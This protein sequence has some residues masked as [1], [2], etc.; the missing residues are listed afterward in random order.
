MSVSHPK[1]TPLQ[2][3]FLSVMA[4][5]D[6]PVSLDVLAQLVP[7]PPSQFFELM[8]KCE[9]LNWICQDESGSFGLSDALPADVR[10]RIEKI[11]SF[12]RLVT[13]VDQMKSNNL[14]DKISFQA[15][16]N[17]L[18]KSEGQ[19][20][21]V[22][23][24]IALAIEA[25]KRGERDVAKEHVRRIDL[26]LP[27]L[28][29]TLPENTW[30]IPESIRLAEYCVVRSVELTTA[31][32]ILSKTIVIAQGTGD[33]RSWT[34][35][36]LVMGRICWFQS[37]IN[38]AVSYLASGKAK[39]EELGDHD[40]LNYAGWFI[41]IYYCLQGYMSK[42]VSYLKTVTQFAW[43]SEEYILAYEAPILLFYCD[44]SRG[45]FHRA[46]GSL[47][48]FRQLAIK[49][50]DYYTAAIYRAMLGIS[51]WAVGRREEA[52]F[53]L[54]G[55]QTDALATDNM[56]S[57]W[58]SLHGLAFLYL[59]EGDFKKGM[60]FFNEL[61]N[62]GKQVGIVQ[63]VFHAIYLE[64]YFNAEQAGC[65]LPPE[66]HFDALFERVMAEPNIDL[67]GVALRLRAVRSIT[68]GKDEE[69]I[70]KDLQE[71]EALLAKCEDPIQL[72]KTKIEMVR[73]YLRN[74][75]YEKAG[76]LAK[77]VYYRELT[78]YGEK[79]FP[80]DL[81]FLLEREKVEPAA[82]MDYASSMEP[83]LHILEELFSAPDDAMKMEL[84]LSTLSRFFRAERSGFFA[85][86]DVKGGTPEL[87]AARHLSRSIVGDQNF[88][89][90]MDLIVD[91]Y[92]KKKPVLSR[93][94][95][96]T[97]SAT[98]KGFLSAM[99]LPIL[100]ETEVRAVLYF[101]NSYLPN[102]FD[103]VSIPM[104]ESL[105]RNLGSIVEKQVLRT[106]EPA[107]RSESSAP[108]GGTVLL[109]SPDYTGIDIV[110]KD[111]KMI[112]LLNQAKRLAQ[113]EAP[114]LIQAETGAGKEVVAQWIHQNSL[115][116]N[117]P[118]VVV[119]LTT[120]SENLVESELFGHEKGAFTGAHHQKI[121]RVEMS[122]G[123]TLF[124]DEIG[125]ISPNLQ[126]KLLRLLEKNTFVRVGGTKTKR[127]DFRLVTATNRNLYEE[128]KTG[129][130]R[131]DL[132]Y[133]LNAL[134]L[135]IPPLRERKADI[136]ALAQFFLTYYTK[137]YNKKLPLL[138]EEQ[139][140]VLKQYNWPG[141]VRELKH[142]IERAVL[143]SEGGRLE[144]DFADQK[145]VVS[146]ENPFSDY[147]TLDEIQRRYI[148]FVLNHTDGKKGGIGSA[149]EIL[150]V[151]RTTLNSRMKKLG[152]R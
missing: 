1:F 29:E 138:T 11:N 83:I 70:F 34:M 92:K 5:F 98:Y 77:E 86:G 143:V 107:A 90:S 112:K 31:I 118:F 10:T 47:D 108:H 106:I 68:E 2:W 97:E 16:N 52:L 42:A 44:I 25:L 130:F 99:C 125:E 9:S 3:E 110:I 114:I 48:F 87:Q 71:S 94:I 76:S 60:S 145:E 133:R 123:G 120:I 50:H 127:A 81:S 20:V 126:V 59:S 105:G 102:C 22:R 88:R 56:L 85:V 6:V 23:D 7:L 128:V 116:C 80:D 95:R 131:E 84:F 27:S 147:P 15:F 12:D 4:A 33:E 103:F 21:T 132:Y 26:L 49:R 101:D 72:A 64:Q 30:F 37:R 19:K 66:W 79:F 41:G 150:D 152:M 115:R 109:A 62:T 58:I 82:A 24:E 96:S 69:L 46:V 129:K 117:K 100:N 73:Y 32:K 35:A 144:L 124:F 139:L 121:G 135:H 122:E 151:N 55:V 113:S 65:Q 17:V 141:N 53:H 104:L 38:D 140:T 13:L 40:I 75:N 149:A 74:N 136:I 142:V 54:E 39:A 36:N 93:N 91:C 78:G 137:K 119:D 63:Y 146:T 61:I 134:E 43:K 57:F 18:R 148:R 67:Q 8:R 89:Q 111:H 14:I 51:L 28:E 45:D